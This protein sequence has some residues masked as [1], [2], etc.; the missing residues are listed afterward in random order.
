[1][2]HGEPGGGEARRPR[3]QPDVDR[4]LQHALHGPDEDAPVP[5]GA[6]AHKA[7]VLGPL[8]ESWGEPREVRVLTPGEHLLEVPALLLRE[9][10]APAVEGGGSLCRG[11]GRAR[12]RGVAPLLPLPLLL[13]QRGPGGVDGPAVEGGGDGDV[14]RA[15]RERGRDEARRR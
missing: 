14:L 9:G 3:L 6:P 8:E 2:L 11:G 12:A 5:R 4:V 10:D 13:L 7:L 1:M 15:L